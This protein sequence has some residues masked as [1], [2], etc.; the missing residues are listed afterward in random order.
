MSKE[1]YYK[2][3]GI[4]TLREHW[5][6]LDVCP[7]CKSTHTFHSEWMNNKDIQEKSELNVY[8]LST[9]KTRESETFGHKEQ[10]MSKEDLCLE[11]GHTW[12]MYVEVVKYKV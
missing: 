4:E 2:E 8:R 6:S 7:S 5:I 9:A 3:N 10:L 12:V 1:E 11:C